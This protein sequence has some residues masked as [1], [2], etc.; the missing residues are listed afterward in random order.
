[1]TTVQQ[2]IEVGCIPPS[3]CFQFSFLDLQTQGVDKSRGLAV[4]RIKCE[5]FASFPN[6]LLQ[7]VLVSQSLG[8]SQVRCQ[9]CALALA[10]EHL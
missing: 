7:V 5:S 2:S 6:R 8:L 9:L 10:T 3:R 1:M 4:L